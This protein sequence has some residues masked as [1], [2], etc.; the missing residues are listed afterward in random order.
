VFTHFTFFCLTFF[1]FP[2]GAEQTPNSLPAVS[3]AAGDAAG[4]ARPETEA[5]TFTNFIR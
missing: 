4:I 2:L 5:R 3:R 1:E